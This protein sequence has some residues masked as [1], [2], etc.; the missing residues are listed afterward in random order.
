VIQ[1]V[2]GQGRGDAPI[3]A[4]GD[5]SSTVVA[6][7]VGLPRFVRAGGAGAIEAGQFVRLAVTVEILLL[8]TSA[9]ERPLPQLTQMFTCLYM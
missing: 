8:A 6:A 1:E 5:V 4:A 9:V 7:G 3:G 2:V